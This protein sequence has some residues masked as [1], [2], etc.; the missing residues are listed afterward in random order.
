MK[1]TD[2]CRFPKYKKIKKKSHTQDKVP[3]LVYQL[4]I[5][6]TKDTT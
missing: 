5:Y 4:Y 6:T 1:L 3:M 2:K